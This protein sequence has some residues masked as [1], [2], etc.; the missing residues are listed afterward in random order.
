MM[1][2]WSGSHGGVVVSPDGRFL[3][4][5][6]QEPALHGWRVADAKD[7]KMGGYP[8][9]VR[10][11]A[12]LGEAWLATSGANGAV[13][14]PFVGATGPMGKQAMEIGWD[15]TALVARVAGDAAGNILVAVLDD[16][17]VWACHLASDRRVVLRA[18]KGPPICA[19]A[20]LPDGRVAWGDE[21]GAAAITDA[22]PI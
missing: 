19:L 11:L 5:S 6:M 15:E 12:F 4:S 13:L 10:G 18:D 2:R 9:K 14:W 17:R 3:V 20:V 8:S 16:G 7:M 21:A 1:L 22:A